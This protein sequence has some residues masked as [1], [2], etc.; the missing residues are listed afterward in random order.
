MTGIEIYYLLSPLAV[1]VI[2]GVATWF[3][4]GRKNAP[5]GSRANNVSPGENA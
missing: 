2:A 3:F 4:V 5:L 1:A